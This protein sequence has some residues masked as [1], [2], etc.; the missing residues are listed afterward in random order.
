MCQYVPSIIPS[1]TA[2]PADSSLSPAETPAGVMEASCRRA[3]VDAGV[4]RMR[5]YARR[6][7]S[8]DSI[9]VLSTTESIVPDD[10][11]AIT[12]EEAER[13]PQSNG[14]EEEDGS[15]TE[16]KCDL[17]EKSSAPVQEDDA[18]GSMKLMVKMN[19]EALNR[20]EQVVKNSQVHE[21][22]PVKMSELLRGK[23]SA[24]TFMTLENISSTFKD[25]H[26]H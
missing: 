24:G 23:T 7:N 3:A 2:A 4:R 15:L 13:R 9:E 16:W 18:D 5:A 21:D 11:T 22:K 10:L 26:Q 17:E 6:A 20:E 8:E 12:E 14:L 19:G 25:L 1:V